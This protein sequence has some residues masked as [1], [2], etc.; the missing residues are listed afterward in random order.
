[1]FLL[2]LKRFRC[3][4]VLNGLFATAEFATRMLTAKPF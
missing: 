1:M 3:Q 2:M 4:P